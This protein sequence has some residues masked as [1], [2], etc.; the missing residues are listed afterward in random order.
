MI[1]PVKHD[2]T[3][4]HCRYSAQSTRAFMPVPITAVTLE[5]EF[6][7]RRRQIN[8]DVMLPAQ[9]DLCERTAALPIFAGQP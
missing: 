6:W 3:S 9:Y 8:R 7:R 4:G 1:S 2:R 5:D